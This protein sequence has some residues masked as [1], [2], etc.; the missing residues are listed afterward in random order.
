VSEGLPSNHAELRAN[1]CRFR[2]PFKTFKWFLSGVIWSEKAGTFL[3]EEHGIYRF[4]DVEAEA[5]LLAAS[6]SPGLASSP[7]SRHLPLP[8]L[9]LVPAFSWLKRTCIKDLHAYLHFQIVWTISFEPLVLEPLVLWAFLSTPI[10]PAQL[11]FP[12]KVPP[13]P[14]G[15]SE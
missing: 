2:P 1:T 9:L 12:C 10:P 3:W 13:T 5:E 8:L 6:L 15:S 14:W 7:E 4:V 11:F